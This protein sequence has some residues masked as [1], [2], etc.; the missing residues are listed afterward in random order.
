MS[1]AQ[2]EINAI[3]QKLFFHLPQ[4]RTPAGLVLGAGALTALVAKRAA[5]SFLRRDVGK[6]ITTGGVDVQESPFY[7]QMLPLITQAKLPL[8]QEGEVEGEYA[9]RILMD[10]GVP[11]NHITIENESFN[12]GE[13]IGFSTKLGL[14]DA[15]SVTLYCLAHTQWR[16]LATFRRHSDAVATVIPFFPFPGVNAT[17]WH[18]HP[19]A[20]EQVRQEYSKL[21]DYIAQGFCVDI[22]INQ[23]LQRVENLRLRQQQLQGLNNG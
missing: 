8:P 10:N 13:N 2:A 21:D 14:N 11:E 5:E 3:T 4:I 16:A 17:N 1:E 6:F 12:T 15:R 9:A 20:A 22:D 18:A 23:E 19:L 7:T